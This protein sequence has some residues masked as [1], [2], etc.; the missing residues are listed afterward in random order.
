MVRAALIGALIAVAA[1]PAA[2]Q[3]PDERAAA[4]AFADAGLRLGEALEGQDPPSEPE[5]ERRCADRL[6]RRTAPDEFRWPMINGL[7]TGQDD[8]R[9]LARLLE[10]PFTQFSLD[11]HAVATADPALRGG[12]TAVRRARRLFAALAALRRID[13]C[14]HLLRWERGG[15]EPTPEMRRR[16][17]LLAA[18][19]RISEGDAARRL[20]RAGERMIELGVPPEEARAFTGGP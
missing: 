17:R 10:P 15:F 3:A 16:L 4:R 8:L 19:D 11:L 2:G 9:P 6:R 1:A 13:V 18:Y 5:E 14:A 7:G 20:V 12:R